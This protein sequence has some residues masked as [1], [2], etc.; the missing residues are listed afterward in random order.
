MT[1]RDSSFATL[2]IFSTLP[3]IL[4]YQ[5]SSDTIMSFQFIENGKIDRAARKLIRS[6]VMKGK[7]VGK[8][9][10]PRTRKGEGEVRALCSRESS[11]GDLLRPELCKSTVDSETNVVSVP[12]AVGNSFSLFTFP[13]EMQPYMR[14]LISQCKD[15]VLIFPLIHLC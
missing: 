12:R 8:V 10:A 7:N 6:H 11:T 1:F 3:L 15:E 4:G 14:G 2:D 13:C 9:R 5:Q